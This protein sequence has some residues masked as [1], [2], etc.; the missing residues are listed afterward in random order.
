MSKSKT[1]LE[2]ERQAETRR[3]LEEIAE[4][5]NIGDAVLVPLMEENSFDV[6]KCV[7]VLLKLIDDVPSN[8]LEKEMAKMEEEERFFEECQRLAKEEE[9]KEKKKRK[10][11]E[12][13]R[14]KEEEK[15]KAKVNDV[16]SE[17]LKRKEELERK[18]KEIKEENEK[19]FAKMRRDLEKEWEARLEQQRKELEEKQKKMEEERNE[20]L[21]KQLEN[22]KQSEEFKGKVDK[23]LEEKKRKQEMEEKDR[24][25]STP[26][27][28]SSTAVSS[29][30]VVVEIK[31]PSEA[32][33]GSLMTVYYEYKKGRP[34][35]SDWIGYYKKSRPLDS[36][37]YYTYQKTGGSEKGKLEFVVP[38]KLGICELRFFQNNSYKAIGRSEPIRVGKDVKVKAELKGDVV[39]CQVVYA[40]KG[41]DHSTWD[42]VGIY[43]VGETENRNIFDG[44]QSYV[45]KD[46]LTLAAPRAPG[47]YVVRYFEFY[48]RYSPLA[49]SEP[50]EVQDKDYIKVS[51]FPFFPFWFLT[52]IFQVLT[53]GEVSLG[54]V[55]EVAW[56]I[57][58]VKPSTKD[59]VAIFK[60]GE[61]NP[62]LCLDRQ[63]THGTNADGSLKFEIKVTPGLYDFVFIAANTSAPLK[64][65][66]SFKVV[67]KNY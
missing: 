66:N 51:C 67:S 6:V 27:S 8:R 29:S 7:E 64:R 63:Y 41:R 18:R 13:E 45:T 4:G 33:G 40:N 42:W 54:D 17:E 32:E 34:S 22:V 52:Y 50:F 26:S 49:E 65:S 61:I 48:S 15:Q 31:A 28:A 62:L 53:E 56:H 14:R 37:D 16:I 57:E 1:E 12:E 10:A 36:S 23:L 3:I 58:S 5:S 20:K 11:E 44:I 46:S 47:Q 38:S 21:K 55:V 25:S 30:D 35:L 59:Y 43:K 19:Q 9:E 2:L 39:H 60:A 24:A